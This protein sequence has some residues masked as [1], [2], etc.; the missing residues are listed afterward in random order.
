MLVKAVE[1]GECKSIV[2]SRTEV[3]VRE[4]TCGRVI[5][6]GGLQYFTYETHPGTPSQVKKIEVGATPT[7]LYND[8]YSLAD[9]YGLVVP[10][11]TEGHENKA[12]YIA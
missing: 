3:D 8:W 12:V 5:V 2:F 9:Q 4:C 11:D 7:I 6:S 10:T 1:C